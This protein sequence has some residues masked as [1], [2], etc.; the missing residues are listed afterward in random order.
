MK[1]AHI[2]RRF[3]FDE[4]GGTESVVWNIAKQQKAQGL[5][6]EILCTSALDKVGIEI[7]EDIPIK[8]FP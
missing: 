3:S 7:V 4:W 1:I 2:V 5:S 6:P 8:R